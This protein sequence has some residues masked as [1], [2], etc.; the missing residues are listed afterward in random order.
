MHYPHF[1]VASH[2]ILGRYR[3]RSIEDDK[4]I[5]IFHDMMCSNSNIV[6]VYV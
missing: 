2:W 4:R 6:G 1:H 3:Q 5:R